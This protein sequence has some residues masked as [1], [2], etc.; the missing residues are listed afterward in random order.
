MN[1]VT[2]RQRLFER[3]SPCRVSSQPKTGVSFPKPPGTPGRLTM[4]LGFAFACTVFV[5]A[6]SRSG[7][8]D[9]RV[10][11]EI[12]QNMEDARRWIVAL[13]DGVRYFEDHT[14]RYMLFRRKGEYETARVQARRYREAHGKFIELRIL[15]FI[16]ERSPL[17]DYRRLTRWGLENGIALVDPLRPRA[18]V[19]DS[20][21]VLFAPGYPGE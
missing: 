10:G 14:V 15:D 19:V 3:F 6:N 1:R 13:A 5:V 20:E 9:S 8:A 21:R 16:V 18:F 17:D 4:M 12:L 7:N 11:N 2:G